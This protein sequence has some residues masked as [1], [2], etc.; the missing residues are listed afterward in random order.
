MEFIMSIEILLYIWI[1][2]RAYLGVGLIISIIISYLSITSEGNISFTFK[3]F[4]FTILLH[5]IVVY[6]FIKEL[7]NYEE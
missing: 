3:E 1:G 6:Y 7:E 5:P 2:V 4:I